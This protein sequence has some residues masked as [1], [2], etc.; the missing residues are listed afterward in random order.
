MHG[1]LPT[2]DWKEVRNRERRGGGQ[3]DER[4][5][6]RRRGEGDTEKYRSG[7]EGRKEPREGQACSDRWEEAAE[8]EEQEAESGL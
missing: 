8:E 5:D 2:D 3:V 4:D 1:S 6:E 7:T